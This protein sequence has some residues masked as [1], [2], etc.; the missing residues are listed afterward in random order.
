[1]VASA[2]SADT[3]TRRIDRCPTCT[4]LAKEQHA[5]WEESSTRLHAWRASSIPRHFQNRRLCNYRPATPQLREAYEIVRTWI[6]SPMPGLVLIGPVGV[7]KTHLCVGAI[8]E[9]VKRGCSAHYAA[10]PDVIGSLRA[11]CAKGAKTRPSAIFDA[12]YRADVW[13]LDEIGA[14]PGTAWEGQQVSQLIDERYRRGQRFIL[15]GNCVENEL[16]T[17]AGE[18]GADRLSECA[19]VVPLEGVSY[20]S[21]AASDVELKSARDDFDLGPRPR[22]LVCDR[23]EL[24]EV[25]RP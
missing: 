5:R 25:S 3:F 16:P 20:R 8:A 23:G 7:G 21:I 12:F 14:T 24:V 15:V 11:G 10:T 6:D 1:V 9:L 18:R 19:V 4:I 17:F 22:T 13:A 2:G